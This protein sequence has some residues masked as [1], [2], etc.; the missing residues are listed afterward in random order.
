MA[1]KAKNQW[2]DSLK[3]VFSSG[4]EKPLNQNQ[5]KLAHRQEFEKMAGNQ[6]K[7]LKMV[8]PKRSA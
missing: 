5:K 2:F 8:L 7:V 6:E 3:Q 4:S 1:T